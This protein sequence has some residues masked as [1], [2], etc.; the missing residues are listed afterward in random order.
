MYHRQSITSRFW[1]RCLSMLASPILRTDVHRPYM[2][3]TNIWFL[4]FEMVALLQGNIGRSCSSLG[5][6]NERYSTAQT[7]DYGRCTKNKQLTYGSSS[8]EV[9]WVN[10]SIQVFMRQHSGHIGGLR[11]AGHV[12]RGCS[13]H[14]CAAAATGDMCQS[15]SQWRL[16]RR[17]ERRLLKVGTAQKSPTD[18]LLKWNRQVA[19]F[20]DIF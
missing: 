12:S 2:W 16:R 18:H 9:N 14:Q 8:S 4:A 3:M 5:N 7:L 13:P 10:D 1:E 19:T 15:S 6:T 20:N 17:C 11:P